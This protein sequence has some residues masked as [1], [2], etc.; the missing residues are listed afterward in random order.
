[1]LNVAVYTPSANTSMAI[2]ELYNH[3]CVLQNKHPEAFFVVAGD[4]NH[5]KLTD[6]LPLFHQHVSMAT[7]GNN[8]L[9][10]VYT[11]KQEA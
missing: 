8:M 1:M 9:D 5:V 2:R 11:N 10:C 3:I 4:F 7:K 6:I